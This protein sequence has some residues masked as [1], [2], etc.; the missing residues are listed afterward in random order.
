MTKP[1]DPSV[2]IRVTILLRAEDGRL[3]LVRHLKEGRRYWLLPGGG[4]DPG[5]PL[6]QAARRE[7]YE[8][9]RV[10]ARGFRFLALRESIDFA[11]GRH[12]QFPI[13]AAVEPDLT[14]LGPGEDPRIEG[15]DL[16]TPE[17]LADRPVFPHFPE[18]LGRLAR[19]EPVAP[20]QT[21][22]WVP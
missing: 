3:V 12:I 22:P 19:N 6:E 13:F 21:L 7:L 14:A 2:R 5:E 17:E 20:F 18:D 15:I 1:I 9:V 16:F 11:G 8:E 10:T 4:Q